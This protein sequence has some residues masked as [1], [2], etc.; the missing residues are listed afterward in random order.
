M[1]PFTNEQSCVLLC[2]EPGLFELRSIGTEFFLA[3]EQQLRYQYRQQANACGGQH[4]S[5]KIK[6]RA[7]LQKFEQYKV[8]IV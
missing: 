3:E 5:Y 4:F 1:Y 2:R 6:E 7:K 8:N